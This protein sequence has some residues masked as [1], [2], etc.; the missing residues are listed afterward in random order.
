MLFQPSQVHL[1]PKKETELFTADFRPGNKLIIDLIIKF[2]K[3]LYFLKPVLN[4]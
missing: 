4:F 2:K 1:K 3:Y